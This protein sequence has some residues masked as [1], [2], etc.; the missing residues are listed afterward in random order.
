ML[1]SI[2]PFIL[3]VSLLPI[4]MSQSLDGTWIKYKSFTDEGDVV[5]DYSLTNLAKYEIDISDKKLCFTLSPLKDPICLEYM[6]KDNV[7]IAEQSFKDSD[8][9]KSWRGVINKIEKDTLILAFPNEK[10]D[11]FNN[12]HF[13]RDQAYYNQYNFVYEDDYLVASHHFSPVFNGSFEDYINDGLIDYNF[14]GE[15]KGVITFDFD[16]SYIALDIF[17]SEKASNGFKRKFTNHIEK[18]LPYW[19]NI[20][21]GQKKYKLY[22]TAKVINQYGGFYT[23]NFYTDSYSGNLK[24]W[25]V[26]DSQ[27][28]KAKAFFKKGMSAYEK[29]ELKEA[30]NFFKMAYQ[31]DHT[32][33]E[34]IYNVAA[35]HL[36]NGQ[37]ND[38]C[39]IW[40]H[41]KERGQLKALAF[42]K[43]HCIN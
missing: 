3:F 1:K 38:A 16:S 43:E 39:A 30:I 9:T 25:Q 10:K 27:K 7:I 5:I 11:G 28:R 15:M 36:E 40:N 26:S 12:I 20:F 31:Q 41:L 8:V 18:S 35:I 42:I 34:S 23:V 4:A 37:R 13:L 22:F 2:L 29:Q 32:F 6:V 33:V 21:G 17:E 24:K 19:T 14:K